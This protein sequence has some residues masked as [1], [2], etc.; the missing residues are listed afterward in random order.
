M[1]PDITGWGSCL[2]GHQKAFQG[3]TSNHRAKDG[4]LEMIFDSFLWSPHGSVVVGIFLIGD[5]NTCIKYQY[6]IHD[7]T[8]LFY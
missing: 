5:A 7:F 2:A 4:G 8:N 3:P 1:G 6:S